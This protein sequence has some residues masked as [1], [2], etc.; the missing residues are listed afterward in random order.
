VSFEQC[1][2]VL[3]GITLILKERR[4]S[5]MRTRYLLFGLVLMV[6]VSLPCA[7]IAEVFE[8]N[9]DDGDISD[10]E[11][12]NKTDTSV[13]ENGEAYLD[14]TNFPQQV[15]LL[16]PVSAKNF[17]ATVDM[18]V[19]NQYADGVFVFR[20]Q[21]P[22]NYYSLFQGSGKIRLNGQGGSAVADQDIEIAN[23]AH[24]LNQYVTYK[25]AA[26]DENIRVYVDD[27]EIMNIDDSTILEAG[28]IGLTINMWRKT[29][30][31]SAY[32]DNFRVESDE[33]RL[34]VDAAG[35]LTSTW[36]RIRAGD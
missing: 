13:V 21:D 10:W 35:K 20:Y 17:T 16:S 23:K 24:M 33:I 27:A 15:I 9:F 25:I 30:H 4:Q 29:L 6:C 22:D 11:W 19:V 18:K 31:F 28:R 34:A 7:G 2:N 26:E 12:I 3:V 14:C 5:I 36:A 32:F 1:G 8:N